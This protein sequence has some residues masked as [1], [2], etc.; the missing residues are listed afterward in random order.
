MSSTNEESSQLQKTFA[1]FSKIAGNKD[2]KLSGETAKHWLKQAGVIG[3][4]SHQITE[5]DADKCLPKLAREGE[6]G[7]D[8]QEFEQYIEDLAKGKEIEANEIKSKLSL[9]VPSRSE[10][11]LKLDEIKDNLSED[12]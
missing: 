11:D 2:G 12:K 7:M 4:E 1:T 8:L 6:D 5:N 10:L 9:A 3:D